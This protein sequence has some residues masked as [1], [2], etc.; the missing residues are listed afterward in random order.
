MRVFLTGSTGFVGS[1]LAPA[2]LA[3]GHEVEALV[4]PGS[5]ARLSQEVRRHAGFRVVEGDA[6]DPASLRGVGSGCEAFIHLVG[7]IRERGSAITFARLH[8]EATRNVVEA[9]RRAGARRFLHMSALGACNGARSR[10]HA[11]KYEAESAVKAGRIPFVIFR[12][13]VIFGPGDS[14]VNLQKRFI[15]PFVPVIVPGDGKSQLQPV[16]IESIVEGFV[17]ALACA[18][19]VDQIYEVGGPDRFTLDQIIETIAEAKGVGSYFKVH[20]P[21]AILSPMVGMLERLPMFPITQDQLVM[22][23][24]DNVCETRKFYDDLKIVPRTF[25]VDALRRYV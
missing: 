11:T 3:A 10:Y 23:S 16:A 6:L 2:L 8:V 5:E 13:S 15:L 24:A 22:L 17:N 7:I 20:V 12:P 14:F 9:A 4:R 19:A 25:G 21:L 18:E 1:H